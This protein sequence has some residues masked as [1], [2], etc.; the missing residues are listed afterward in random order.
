MR[1]IYFWDQDNDDPIGL[2][3]L[4]ACVSLLCAFF[5][6]ASVSKSYIVN[7]KSRE[8]SEPLEVPLHIN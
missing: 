8:I 3:V 2:N 1:I 4:R 7:R 5:T 6:A